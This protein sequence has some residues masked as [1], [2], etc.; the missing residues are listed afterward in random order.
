MLCR[1]LGVQNIFCVLKKVDLLAKFKVRIERVFEKNELND[2]FKAQSSGFVQKNKANFEMQKSI[3]KVDG[4]CILL[5][6]VQHCLKLHLRSEAAFATLDLLS[7][8]ECQNVV[9]Q[10]SLLGFNYKF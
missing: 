6:I 9:E 10:L 7:R 4:A 3:S 2:N 1:I 5:I 8:F